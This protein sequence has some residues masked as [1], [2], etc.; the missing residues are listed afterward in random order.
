MGLV[1]LA[2]RWLVAAIF[3]RSGL[4]KATE[5]ATFQSA[6]A[7]YRLLPSALERPVALSLPFAE[8]GSAILL[9]V[10]VLPVIV[11]AALA[12]LLM[13]FAAAIAV[14][15]ARGRMFEC[16]CGGSVAPQM[17]S[18]RHVAADLVLAAVAAAIAAAPPAAAQ[19]WPGP[20]GPAQVVPSGS[21]IPVLLTVLLCLVLTTVVR[22]ALVASVLTAKVGSRRDAHPEP[23]DSRRH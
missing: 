7:N 5:L 19:L 20:A 6:V 3:L 22:R 15:L 2:A 23:P 9:A 1:L 4:A 18:W 16:G 11:A 17:I 14:N 8:I 12:L 10:G 13:I 21:V